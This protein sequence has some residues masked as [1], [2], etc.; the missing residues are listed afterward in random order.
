MLFFFFFLH[1][2]DVRG[3]LGGPEFFT[4]LLL[5]PGKSGTSVLSIYL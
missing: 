1:A 3:F 2:E 4:M 5:E